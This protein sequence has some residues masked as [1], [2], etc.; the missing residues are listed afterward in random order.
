M[1]TIDVRNVR[2]DEFDAWSDAIDI[3]FISPNNRGDGVR[4]RRWFDL[5]R[6]W[7]AFDDGRPVGTFRGVELEL[8]VRGGAF[9]P[10][11]GV[12]AVTVAPTH[13]R[14]GLLSRMMAAELGAARERGEVLAGL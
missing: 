13:R 5:N 8:T 4:R 6:C 10:H 1:T 2:E 12:S 11:D 7:G 3:G 14:R 9:V